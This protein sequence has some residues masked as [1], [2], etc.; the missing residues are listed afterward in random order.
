M[1]TPS[2]FFHALLRP[3]IL[4][5]LRASGFHAARPSVVDSLTDIAARYLSALCLSTASH[6]IHNHG[7]AGDYT[8]VDV[9]MALQDVGA[10]QPQRM[11]SGLDGGEDKDD[12]RAVDE[13]VA[14]FSG[15]RMREL[16]DMGV[17]DGEMEATDYLS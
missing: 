14:W 12:G 2:A 17:G 11:A 6:A 3:S 5:I 9:R 16:M 7:D 13:F 8:V 15:Q 1:S 4:Q 10:L